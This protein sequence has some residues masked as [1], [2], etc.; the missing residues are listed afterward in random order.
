MHGFINCLLNIGCTDGSIRLVGGAV[1]SAGRVE[2]CRNQVWGTVCNTMW[3]TQDSNVLCRQ[4][5]YSRIGMEKSH[6]ALH[7]VMMIFFLWE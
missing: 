5:G 7:C 3:S 1:L 2:V 6:D 4:L